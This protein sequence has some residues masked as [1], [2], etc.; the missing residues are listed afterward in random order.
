MR[1]GRPLAAP[2]RVSSSSQ[3]GRRSATKRSR[4]TA[5]FYEDRISV[6]TPEGVTLEATLAGL[7][8]RFAAGLV[9]QV[10]RWSVLLA[11][12]TLLAILEEGIGEGLSAGGVV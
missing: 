12:V 8:S 3:D 2:R 4:F 11:L 10:L 5:V 6:A 1:S 7:G 9:D